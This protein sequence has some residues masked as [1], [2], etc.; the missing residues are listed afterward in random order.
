MK[1]LIDVSHPAIVHFFKNFAN[2]MIQKGN[3]ILF[4]ARDKDVTLKL[5]QH[6]NFNYIIFGKL[7]KNFLGKVFSIIKF[8]AMFIRTVMKFKPDIIFSYGSIIAAHASFI[9]RIPNITIHDT[10][11]DVLIKINRLFTSVY[12][13]PDSFTINLG[14]KHIRFKGF[15]ELA[16]L[17]PKFYHPNPK[18]LNKLGLKENEKYVLLRFVSWEAHDDFGKSGF[19]IS[20]IRNLVQQFSMYAKVFISS[21]YL[22]PNDLQQYQLETNNYIQTG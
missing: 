12:L 1:I 6:Y 7:K 13:T 21:E 16:F 17:H 18:V 14:K 10:D 4:T 19:S 15:K 22:L 9:F 2:I 20:E 8:E 11:I 3:Q 5:L